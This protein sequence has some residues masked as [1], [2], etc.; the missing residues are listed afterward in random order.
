M[1]RSTKGIL[2]AL[3]LISLAVIIFVSGHQYTQAQQQSGHD[4]SEEVETTPIDE[5]A[6]HDHATESAPELIDEHAGH[7][8]EAEEEGV[9]HLEPEAL[10]A[11]GITMASV[12]LRTLSETIA[13]TGS[14]EPHPDGEAIIGSLIEGRVVQF[15]ADLGD[16]VTAGQPLCAIESPVAWETESAFINAKAELEYLQSDLSRQQ[17]LVEEGIGSQKEL[18]EIDSRLKSAEATFIA[19]ERTLKAISLVCEDLSDLTGLD[20]PS[21]LIMLS[22]PVDGSVVERTARVGM[23]VEPDADL[24][25]IVDL[26][27]L[28]VKVEIPE[29]YLSSLYPGARATISLLH[30]VHGEINGSIDR[31]ASKINPDTRTAAA[32][33]TLQNAGDSFVPN[34]FVSAEIFIGKA[35]YVLAVPLESVLQDEHGDNLVYVQSAPHEFVSR[36]I[37]TGRRMDGWVEVLGGLEKGMIVVQ[38]G[39]F[40]IQS[41]SLKGQFSP[42]CV[43]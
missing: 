21:G 43:H 16:Q 31:V 30:Q 36:E 37:T 22:S 2:L 40:A 10:T 23:Y 7:D 9:V 15:F 38:S 6:G 42:G 4:H 12:E 18:Q 1:K 14:V 20:C 27:R 17:M 25:H 13:L 8:H 3:P 35:E 28:R 29:R 26:N 5:H 11:A 34:A 24:F 39:A 32:Y 41:E 19:A 33:V